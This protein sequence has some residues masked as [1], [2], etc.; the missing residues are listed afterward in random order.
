MKKTLWIIQRD[1]KKFRRAPT[2]IIISIVMPLIFLTFIGNSFGRNI[3]GDKILFVNDSSIPAAE[4]VYDIL[5]SVE[6]FDLENVS[7]ESKAEDRIL[8]DKA[9]A[10]FHV[11]PTVENPNGTVFAAFDN[12]DILTLQA[13]NATIL[14]LMLKDPF[15]NAMNVGFDFSEEL[16]PEVDYIAYVTPGVI[17]MAIFMTSFVS[18]GIVL[19]IDRQRGV[20][21]SYMTTPLKT[22][23]LIMGITLSGVLKATLSATIVLILAIP[24]ASL[25][26]PGG[27]TSFFTVYGLIL[28][29]GLGL[30]GLSALIATKVSRFEELPGIAMP[31]NL[32][33]FFTSGAIA[34]INTYPGW[35]QAF[36]KINPMTYSVHAIRTTLL[37]GTPIGVITIDILCLTFFALLTIILSTKALKRTIT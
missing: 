33:L 31:I 22:P 15:L 19:T 23:E 20:M 27:I 21:E 10:F 14:P 13:I 7:T 37:K 2:L 3:E 16:Y 17:V 6:N 35:M 11:M 36:A 24:F 26:F 32:T 30:L 8:D 1:L 18:G 12:S 25:E 9:K 34:P 29:T 4:Q 28:L 5:E